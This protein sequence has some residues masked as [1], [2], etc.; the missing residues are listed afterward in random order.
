MLF[1]EVD[2]LLG[3]RLEVDNARDCYT[4]TEV[5]YLFQRLEEFA[6][7]VVMATNLV[8]NIDEAFARHMHH[9][10]VFPSEDA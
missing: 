9:I 10:V 6:G 7:I 8:S 4:N 5:N 3:K 2:A 1:D